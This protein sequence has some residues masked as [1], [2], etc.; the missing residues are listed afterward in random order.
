MKSGC[1]LIKPSHGDG[2]SHPCRRA[3]CWR[4][5]WRTDKAWP[6]RR[7]R[8]PRSGNFL[9]S[10]RRPA[11]K[12]LRGKGGWVNTTWQLYIVKYDIS[13]SARTWG[14]DVGGNG[15]IWA[16]AQ[17]VT[18]VGLLILGTVWDGSHTANWK[19]RLMGN[20]TEFLMRNR[21][22]VTNKRC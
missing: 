20:Q 12:I 1:D 22:L 10:W 13:L 15:H 18:L 8:Q 11:L 16:E 14:A 19:Q 17:E 4:C 7:C 3:A 5:W 2:V 21:L 9:L 6:R